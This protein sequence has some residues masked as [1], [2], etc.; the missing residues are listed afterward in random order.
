MGCG[1]SKPDDED[2]EKLLKRDK[3]I[4]F[5]KSTCP[6]SD[7]VKHMVNETGVSYKVIE[8]DGNDVQPET[9]MKLIKFTKNKTVPQVFV[10]GTY[11]GGML[12]IDKLRDRGTLGPVLK[13]EKKP[14]WC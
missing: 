5:T 13:G 8:V 3:V 2:L 4:I 7:F 11:V 14:G 10:N 12:K 9:L 6:Y 1:P